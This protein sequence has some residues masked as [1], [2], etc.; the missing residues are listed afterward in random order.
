MAILTTD[1]PKQRLRNA[2]LSK[3]DFRDALET[4]Y[5]NVMIIQRTNTGKR[6]DKNSEIQFWIVGKHHK[7]IL[8]N[9][10]L[11]NTEDLPSHIYFDSQKFW[12]HD[13]NYWTIQGQPIERTTQMQT[14]TRRPTAFP[15]QI[16]WNVQ[17]FHHTVMIHYTVFDKTNI[18]QQLK[19]LIT[20]FEQNEDNTQRVYIGIN[21]K[22]D[23]CTLIINKLLEQQEHKEIFKN[24]FIFFR[25]LKTYERTIQ[26]NNI[27]HVIDDRY[28]YI[29]KVYVS[30][31]NYRNCYHF[32]KSKTHTKHPPKAS[33]IQ[34][35]NTWTELIQQLQQVPTTLD[36]DRQTTPISSFDTNPLLSYTE[37]KQTQLTLVMWNTNSLRS[38]HRQGHLLSFLHT[39]TAD[40]IGFT[41][42]RSS[43]SS[44]LS[45]P[46]VRTILEQKGF[47]YTYW[48]PA[49]SNVGQFGT[50]VLSRIRPKEVIFNTGTLNDEGRVITLIFD[51]FIQVLSY[52]PTLGID[53]K[54]QQLTKQRRRTEFD[55]ALSTHCQE[56]K[57]KYKLPLMLAGDL[58][59]CLTDKDIWKKELFNSQFPSCS[60]KEV[61]DITRLMQQQQLCSAYD[62]FPRNAT[63]S[64]EDRFTFFF[65]QNHRQGMKIDHFLT[66][67]EWFQSHNINDI[68]VTDV[69][70]LHDQLGSDHLPIS[71]TLHIPE[72]VSTHHTAILGDNEEL[73]QSKEGKQT[74]QHCLNYLARLPV[75]QKTAVSPFIF[76]GIAYNSP[77][78]Q[79]IIQATNEDKDLYK[80][81]RDCVQIL[82][83]MYTEET[84]QTKSPKDT[85]NSKPL[86]ENGHTTKQHNDEDERIE[87]ALNNVNFNT[88]RKSNKQQNVYIPHI[89]ITF[90]D[91]PASTPTMLDTGAN[92]NLM[93]LSNLQHH[94]GRQITPTE[95]TPTDITLRVGDATTTQVLGSYIIPTTLNNTTVATKFYIMNNT[96]FGELLGM[97]FIH[98]HDARIDARTKTFSFFKNKQGNRIEL[99]FFDK[100]GSKQIQEYPLYTTEETILKPGHTI[101]NTVLSAQHRKQFA[102]K[103]GAIK[104]TDTLSETHNLLTSEGFTY[105]KSRSRNTVLLLNTTSHP[106][107]INRGTPVAY[108]V[109]MTPD[110]YC[111]NGEGFEI[112]T[113]ELANPKTTPLPQWRTS[114]N[115]KPLT[116]NGHTTS[117]PLTKDDSNTQ[118][119][120]STTS[121]TDYTLQG[122][123]KNILPSHLIEDYDEDTLKEL[124]AQPGLLEV[125]QQLDPDLMH[126]PDKPSVDQLQQLKQLLAKRREIFSK[127]TSKPIHVRHYATTI[128]HNNKP[129]VE[130]IR[131][132]TAIEV[133]EW[134]KHV[135]QLLDNGTVEYSTSPWRSASFL[136][137]KPSGDGYRF[138]TDYRKANMQVPKQHW[139]LVRID[140]ALSA[141]GGA[142]VISSC[143]AN[144]AYH[145]IPLADE[146]SKQFT[147]FA[148]PTCQLQYT[149][150]PQGYKNSVSEYSKFTSTIL[151]ELQWQCCLTYLDDFLIWSK[152]YDTHLVALDKVFCRLEYYGVQLSP[153]KSMFCRKE[154]P[155]LGHVIEPGVGIKPNPKLIESI[156]IIQY[157][158]D[159]KRMKTFLQKCGFYRKMIPLYSTLISPL[160]LAMNS[161]K[162]PKQPTEEQT[163]AFETLKAGLS[164]KPII[165]IPDLD[166][167]AKPFFVITDASKHGLSGILLQRQ[168][169]GLLHP[170]F[171]ASR[172]TTESE[173]SRYSQYQ[174]EMAAIVWSLGVFKPYLRHKAVPFTLQTD[175]KSL[176]WL[177][178]TD[179]SL[180]AKWVWQLTEFDFTIQHLKG[181]NNPADMSSRDPNNVFDGYYG[182]DKLEPLFTDK[183]SKI[184]Q[185]IVDTINKRHEEPK[186]VGDKQT[187]V[188]TQDLTNCQ[189][190]F[191][192]KRK[193]NLTALPSQPIDELDQKHNDSETPDLSQDSSQATQEPIP[194][195]KENQDDSN[196][197]K[198]EAI[199]IMEYEFKSEEAEVQHIE[200]KDAQLEEQ[201]QSIAAQQEQKQP[202]IIPLDE[203]IKTINEN[204]SLDNIRLWQSEDPHI[205]KILTKISQS[206]DDTAP[207]HKLYKQQD[208]LLYISN[209]TLKQR[210]T[211]NKNK[212]R[213]LALRNEHSLVIP[214]TTIPNTTIQVKWAIL[215]WY[216]G[217]PVSGHG[218][219]IATYG[220]I[221]QNYYWPNLMKDVKRWIAACNPCQ[222]RKFTKPRRQGQHRSV[223]QT[224]PFEAVS[225]DLVGPFPI[226][227]RGNQYILTIVDHFTRYPITVPIPDK[228]QET[229]MAALKTHLFLALP[230]W[231][232][233]II[234]DKGGE[235]VNECIKKVYDKLGVKQILTSADNPQAN[236]GE[237]FHRYMNAA[238][239]LFLGDKARQTEWEQ[240]LDCATYVYRCTVNTMT[241]ISPFFALYGRHPD[242]PLD[243]I[244]NTTEEQFNSIQ[245]YTES[246]TGK[247]HETY[248]H[249]HA[250][251]TK[252]ALKNKRYDERKTVSDYK[253][254]ESIWLWKKHSP[255]KLDWRFVGPHKIISKTNDSSYIVE[256]EQHKDRL[257]RTIQRTTKNVSVRHLRPYNPWTEDL[258]DTSP[259]W[260]L[261]LNKEDENEHHND[262]K[263]LATGQFCII[264]CYA[265]TD[266]EQTLKTPFLLGKIEKLTRSDCQVRLYGN[267]DLNALGPQHPGWVHLTKPKPHQNQQKWSARIDFRQNQK[268]G[269]ISYSSNMNIPGKYTHHTKIPPNYILY[270]GFNID[271]I[272]KRIPEYILKRIANDKYLIF[273]F[274]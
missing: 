269:Y 155:Y 222:R 27:T 61:E 10:D 42:L 151:G 241:G 28:G 67:K 16:S 123:Y 128:P 45:I 141:L 255:S 79:T 94:I 19:E 103:F 46:G 254:G 268:K 100:A 184:M 125:S 136:V 75:T 62:T 40:V 165:A 253:A 114:T 139:P 4:P 21:G 251:Q 185:L 104:R 78:I 257:G 26:D 137:K 188:T 63:F 31:H 166:P 162:F 88:K 80:T 157:P 107:R 134:K 24:R 109:P 147:S 199:I 262:P 177:M 223:L 267:N 206:Q 195:T 119:C 5:T 238:I 96:A 37:Q 176:L 86:T 53:D 194:D 34:Q 69:Q 44:I 178:K 25:N 181:T 118:Q 168:E 159:K 271:N 124:F 13:T 81:V 57:N 202:D 106:I 217:L 148:G 129:T 153:K 122:G 263:I 249:M 230:F 64:K 51:K 12:A 76:S 135:T 219:V 252:M 15:K 182:E 102:Y 261:D 127:D 220:A 197:H 110:Q 33:G 192:T 2:L 145:Q 89:D 18:Q 228:T 201:A 239:A 91:N 68:K 140:A 38:V 154:L 85:T 175:C 150:L 189:T 256:I 213:F 240:F 56:L 215:R 77:I 218:G 11:P 120:T 274:E 232:R 225:V 58:N 116:E 198:D 30:K 235:F 187:P 39:T 172:T 144:A 121:T 183:H 146:S 204:L 196:E 266:I 234:S 131:P 170:I 130:R 97:E 48:N 244:L 169:D 191:K 95:L 205:Q 41:E 242:R 246:I 193:A 200:Q 132:Y 36:R 260:M 210:A 93:Q 126:L 149:T 243:F 73:I 212:V 264:P 32:T 49:T 55:E 216:H 87:Q 113:E 190:F 47:R 226:N 160:Q 60:P 174:L 133:Q 1:N 164:S 180:A 142:Q 221:R 74:T 245:E 203:Q 186:Q 152:D 209:K 70:I 111:C 115:S 98:E 72:G 229:V 208:G 214:N 99:P 237:R 92:N 7:G 29:Q 35:V 270:F 156:S 247:L 143:D 231:P 20:L 59:I 207:I 273:D 163:E 250:N 50:A 6:R 82:T 8:E 66:P 23:T 179:S 233:R 101:V 171:Y 65:N 211:T 227:E 22:R 272:T 259:Q 265:M 52:T 258:A 248:K 9:Q 224:R 54:T 158:K 83:H 117:E 161:T 14:D 90:F 112:D 108:Y 43:M 17:Q 3:R 105:L 173:N 167:N 71:L 138:V 84:N 236:Q